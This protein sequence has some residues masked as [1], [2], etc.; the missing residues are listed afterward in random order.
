MASGAVACVDDTD[1]EE[2]VLDVALSDAINLSATL[3]CS[4]PVFFPAVEG[5]FLS[6]ELLA[7]AA[8]LLLLPPKG[9]PFWKEYAEA[10][11]AP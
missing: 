2:V 7:T 3:L 1:D 4:C 6:F 11:G 5:G 8:F 10:S 9:G